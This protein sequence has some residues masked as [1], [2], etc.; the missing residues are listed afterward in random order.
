M[1]KSCYAKHSLGYQNLVSYKRQRHDHRN[2]TKKH[3]LKSHNL[4]PLSKKILLKQT[5]KKNATLMNHH[6]INITKT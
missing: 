4:M 5:K 1:Q 3:H 2:Q 6:F